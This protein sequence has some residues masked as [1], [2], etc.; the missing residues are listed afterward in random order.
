MFRKKLKFGIVSLRVFP[1]LHYYTICQI[2]MKLSETIEYTLDL[3][4]NSET[5]KLNGSFFDIKML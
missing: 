3:S 2:I 4:F 1:F 5:N